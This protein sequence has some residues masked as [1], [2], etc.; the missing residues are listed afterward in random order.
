MYAALNT[1]NAP[2]Y[3][4]RDTA[5]NIYLDTGSLVVT[6]SGATSSG[7]WMLPFRPSQ[8][9]QSWMYVASQ[10]SYTK[11]SAPSNNSVMVYKVGIAEPQNQ[12]EACPAAPNLAFFV[13]TANNQW[14]NSGTAGAPSNGNRASDTLG[15]CILDPISADNRSSCQVE[16]S[17]QYQIG[18]AVILNGGTQELEIEDVLPPVDPSSILAIQY[19][20]GNTG[21]CVI[22][23]AQSPFGLGPNATDLLVLCVVG[24]WSNI[25][26]T[27]R[28]PWS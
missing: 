15:V 16:A 20:S 25:R 6:L 17:N 12:V 10:G 4:A 9:P 24:L 27:Q 21:A 1:N 2:R 8:S 28:S 11:I 5:N 26:I 18:E 23:P 13:P 3:L 7:V 22:F 14:N 19:A